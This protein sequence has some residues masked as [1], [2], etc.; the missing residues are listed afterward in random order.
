MEPTITVALGFFVL[1]FLIASASA[2]YLPRRLGQ[3]H[4]AKWFLFEAPDVPTIA[5]PV[6]A[7]YQSESDTD[8]IQPA[9]QILREN[10]AATL[11][12]SLAPH[13]CA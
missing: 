13:F 8:A 7:A 11:A 6:F 9:L 12:G 2:G 5:Y 1:S 4:L 3:T 10:A